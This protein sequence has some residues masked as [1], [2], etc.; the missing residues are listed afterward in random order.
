MISLAQ[1]KPEDRLALLRSE[2]VGGKLVAMTDD[3]TNDALVLAQAD[4]GP[5]MNARTQAA[6]EAGNIVNLDSGS[7]WMEYSY[8]ELTEKRTTSPST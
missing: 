2:Q 6:K 7:G 8:L 3:G 1:A 5:A 4:V